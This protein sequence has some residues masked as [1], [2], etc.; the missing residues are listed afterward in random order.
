M[1]T[2]TAERLEEAR[3]RARLTAL[4]TAMDLTPERTGDELECQRAG[5]IPR[6]RG[7]ALLAVAASVVVVIAAVTAVESTRHHERVA[8]STAGNPRSSQ[9]SAITDAS[10]ATGDEVSDLPLVLPTPSAGFDLSDSGSWPGPEDLDASRSTP[11]EAVRSYLAATMGP[12]NAT[13]STLRRVPV[14]TVDGAVTTSVTL[15]SGETITMSSYHDGSGWTANSF[16]IGTTRSYPTAA[17]GGAA[18][19]A[20]EIGVPVVA[21]A[22]SGR[23]WY[24]SG[25]ATWQLELGPETMGTVTPAMAGLQGDQP[26]I[27]ILV[28]TG[29]DA[30]EGL[31]LV[32]LDAT[33]NPITL[34]SI[35]GLNCCGPDAGS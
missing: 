28:P 32:Y 8:L 24:R 6:R 25:G 1:S 2:R 9:S 12:T 11:D 27:R 4:A 22:A 19:S 29:Q 34:H 20:T 18:N 13:S 26:S 33:G 31:V 7:R 15:P 3:V 30:L 23:L 14:V 17:P 16:G 5:A 35:D 21:G 10:L